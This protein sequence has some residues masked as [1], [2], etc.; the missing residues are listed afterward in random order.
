MKAGPLFKTAIC[1]VFFLFVI[2][3]CITSC[4]K[5][6]TIESSLKND[7]FFKN[8]KEEVEAFF[9]ISTANVSK[10]IISK[11]QIAQQKSSD[12]TIQQLSRKIEIHENQLLG[13]I[14]K[15]ATSRL[16]VITE[17]NATHKRYLYDLIDADGSNFNNEYLD[18]LTKSLSEQ[19][20]LF[21]SISKETND[22]TILQL[23]LHY[24][25]EHYKLLRETESLRNQVKANI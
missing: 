23:V 22:K 8:D 2:L 21:E 17:I 19:I 25:P 18:S 24:L 15:M 1:K 3:I 14:S 20:E 9:F 5:N 12:S 10:S 7:V 4:R 16:I 13:E 11:S 6:S